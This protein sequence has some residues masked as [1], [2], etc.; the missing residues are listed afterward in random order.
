[1]KFHFLYSRGN[2]GGLKQR[3]KGEGSKPRRSAH[4]VTGNSA[5]ASGEKDVFQDRR[6]GRRRKME[7][8]PTVVFEFAQASGEGF[9]E[10]FFSASELSSRPKSSSS[11]GGEECLPAARYWS[12]DSQA[13]PPPPPSQEE[14]AWGPQAQILIPAGSRVPGCLLRSRL[15]NFSRGDEES[16][17]L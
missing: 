2:G 12:R 6:K 16:Q 7:S 5:E 8:Q 1:M 11:W 3:R 4:L 13:S 14:G 10:E 9:L 15:C 17:C